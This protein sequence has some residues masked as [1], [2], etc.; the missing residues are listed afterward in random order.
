MVAH[1]RDTDSTNEGLSENLQTAA[2]EP[3]RFRKLHP[4]LVDA[5]KASIQRPC[6]NPR[7]NSHSLNY[8]NSFI[9]ERKCSL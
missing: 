6:S 3:T 1:A 8:T 2:E 4:I 5:E 9:G 7:Q